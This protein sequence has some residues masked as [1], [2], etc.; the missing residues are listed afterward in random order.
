M[1]NK[2]CMIC[3]LGIE[4]EKEQFVEVK[5]YEKKDV[6]LSKGYYHIKCFRD[7]LNGTDKMN[8]LQ[9]AAMSFINGAKKKVGIEDEQEVILI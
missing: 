7:R 3:K 8:K 1:K 5:H 4:L 6:I 2:T 9:S